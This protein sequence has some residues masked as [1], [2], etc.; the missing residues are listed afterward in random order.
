VHFPDGYPAASAD[1]ARWQMPL[2][3]LKQRGADL[4]VPAETP[5]HRKEWRIPL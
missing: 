2:L 1:P 4:A 3:N 5:P